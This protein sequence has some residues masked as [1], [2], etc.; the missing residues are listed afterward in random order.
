MDDFERRI[1][2]D[3]NDFFFYNVVLKKFDEINKVSILDF[4]K[5]VLVFKIDLVEMCEKGVDD[6]EDE[7]FNIF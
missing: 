4:E 1:K 7:E 6:I 3:D 2:D 5:Y